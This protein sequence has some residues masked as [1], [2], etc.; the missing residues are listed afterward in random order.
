M[1][2]KRIEA[3]SRAATTFLWW[4]QSNYEV[5]F[6]FLFTTLQMFRGIYREITD[7]LD[8]NA[9]SKRPRPNCNRWESE[10]GWIDTRLPVQSTNQALPSC[11][12]FRI[13]RILIFCPLGVFCRAS[14]ASNID[15]FNYEKLGPKI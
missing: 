3:I 2:W 15:C 11:F 12:Y 5:A 4:S 10:Q 1:S 13:S 7:F 8:L 9:T 6:N 14:E